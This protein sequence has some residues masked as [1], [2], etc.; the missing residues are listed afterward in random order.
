MDVSKIK[1]SPQEVARKLAKPYFDQGAKKVVMATCCDRLFAGIEVPAECRHC[2]NSPE[3]V[4]FESLDAVDIEKI[5]D[6]TKLS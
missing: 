1:G 3:V 2:K 5:P 4:V 6:N